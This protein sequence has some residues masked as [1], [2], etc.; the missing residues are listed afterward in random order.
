MSG[1]LL[2][3]GAT[4]GFGE[5]TARRFAEDGRRMV[6]AGRRADRLESL[7][8]ELAAPCHPLALDVRNREEVFEHLGGLP[9]E[10]AEIEILV[11]NA[12]LA[13][14]LEPAPK[15]DLQDWETMV[16]TNVKGLMYCTR[17][18]LPGMVE[19]K[20]GHVV[21]MGS[22][23]GRWPYPGANVYGATKAF[24]E[25][26][27]NNLRSD[28]GGTGVRI[29]NIEP[30]LSETEFSVVRF[31]GDEKK[32][33]AVY[34]GTEPLTGPDIAEVVHWVVSQPPHVN[35]NRVEVMATDQAWGP[36]SIHRRKP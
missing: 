25:Q 9:S 20:G 36:F 26:F 10:F 19:R 24:V 35:I 29:T 23:A 7:A 34:R 21:N 3:T 22:V 18:L 32:A 33:A 2:I 16:D 11:N 31:K 1:T 5:A 15:A 4:S 12:G 17:A 14:G 30:G 28:L 6:L 13:L 27:S 8:A